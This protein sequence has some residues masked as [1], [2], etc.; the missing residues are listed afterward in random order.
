MRLSALPL[1]TLKET[2]ADAQIPSH[3]LMLKAGLIRKVAAGIYTWMPVGLKVLRRVEQVVREEMDRA[4][5]FEL[6]MPNVQP[7][8]LWQE[9]ERW[10]QF[11]P[12]L[13]RF[14]DQN[15]REFCFGP[16]HEEV[17]T[18]IAR[19]ELKSYKQL[20]VTYYQIQTKFRDEIRPRFGVMRAR[21]FL[22]KD[23]YS[24]HID[25]ASLSATYQ[26]MHDAYSRIFERLGLTFRAVEADSGAIGGAVS[27]EFQVLAQTGE[28]LIAYSDRSDYA[29]NVEQAVAL[30]PAE[31]RA[32]A[33]DALAEVA[34]PG[35][36]SIDAVTQ[37]LDVP[38]AHCLKTL[39]VKAQP[40]G[41]HAVV[42]LVLRGDHELNEIKAAKLDGVALPLTLA[43]AAEVAETANCAPGYIGPVGLRCPVIADHSAANLADFVCGANK[44]D[45]HLRHVNWARDLPEP[46]TADLRNV[47][48]GDASPDGNGT[49]GLARGI[50][51]GH[52]FQLGRKYADSM[53]ASVLDQNGR[54]TSMTMG[55]YGIGVSR[56]VAA[57]IEQH[58]DDKG[59]VWPDAMTPF[60]I[61]LVPLNIK[62]SERT[63]DAADALYHS[64][65]AAGYDVLLDDRDARPGFKFA[66]MELLG[67]P[68]RI[69][70]GERG[71]DAGNYEYKARADADTQDVGVDDLLAFLA[72]R[73]DPR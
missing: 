38:A 22:M 12:L 41:D 59:I 3:R 21:E 53:Q 40:G 24:F 2:P 71:L 67:I 54:T 10:D 1:T 46:A 15:E 58:H 73:I 42:A 23:A 49:L 28:D 34:T 70:I 27:H 44:D 69:V 45:A 36:R 68:H 20:P 48:E 11:G 18:D 6:L 51:V 64:L 19:R 8:E 57:A 32:A 61:A 60:Q 25:D 55:C 13:L 31:P 35:A 72:Q 56:I 16:T 30:A 52:I 65:T 37:F 47:V 63:R 17:I 62:K 4:G 39:L 43:S 14:R 33:T 29:A 5:A 9:S 66:D 7:A 26:V 50:E